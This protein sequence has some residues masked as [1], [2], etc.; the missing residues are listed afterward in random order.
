M[1]HP[2]ARAITSAGLSFPSG[3]NSL[4]GEPLRNLRNRRRAGWRRLLPCWCLLQ[5]LKAPPEGP[6]ASYHR[7]RP[8][9]RS[10]TDEGQRL[11]IGFSDRA[12]QRRRIGAALH[13]GANRLDRKEHFRSPELRILHVVGN[14]AV[15]VFQPS[16]GMGNEAAG[17]RQGRFEFPEPSFQACHLTSPSESA[18]S[19]CR[20]MSNRSAHLAVIISS[21]SV[22]GI[23][24]DVNVVPALSWN[25][26]SPRSGTLI[27]S[28]KQYRLGFFRVPA[29]VLA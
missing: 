22:A 24:S 26:A 15:P 21:Y 10:C 27:G 6:V 23:G 19:S 12:D 13:Y 7:V 25:H 9:P 11:F 5:A 4:A 28:A 8:T 3:T 16:L 17:V 20:A 1:V 18:A 14:L 2:N 29:R